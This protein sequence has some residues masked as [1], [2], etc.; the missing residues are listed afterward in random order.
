MLFDKIVGGEPAV[1][2]SWG[3]A[4]SLQRSGRHFCGGSII[5]PLHIITAAHCVTDPDDIIRNTKVVAAIDKLTQSTLSTAQVRSIVSV[6]SHPEYDSG[7]NANDIAVLRL[8]QPL[9]ISYEGGTARLCIP[10]VVPM[11]MSNNYPVSDSSLVAIGWGK[12]AS[13]DT[14][15]PSNLHLQ[16]VTLYAMSA[17]HQMCKDTINYPQIQFCAAVI[18]GGKD[19]CQG[20]SGG[21][22]MHFES[23][24]RQW[25]LAGVTSYGIGC[26]L[27]NFAGVYTRASVY[28]DW[29]RLIVNDNFIELP[30]GGSITEPPITVSSTNPPVIHN[31]TNLP[32]NGASSDLINSLR[33][34]LL[35]YWS[36]ALSLYAFA[37]R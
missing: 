9:N 32:V 33:S 21:P 15:I 37:R 8:D 26:G 35:L 13:E 4:V 22:L 27:P 1:D 20:D 5:S 36:L 34:I 6:F 7:S 30:I 11:N 17:D 28:G 16:Q 23:K 12:L 10:R 24:T 25:V 18:G 2:A 3:W 31:F 29:L 19:T 14:S